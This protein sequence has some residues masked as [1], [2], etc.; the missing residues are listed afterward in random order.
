MRKKRKTLQPEEWRDIDG[1][2]GYQ[3]SNTGYVRSYWE[4]RRKPTGYGTYR[5]LVDNPTIMPMSD[6][7]NGYMKVAIRS[8]DNRAYCRKVHKLVADAFLPKDFLDDSVEYTVDHIRS[9][10]EGKLDNSIGNLQW[11]SRPDNIKKA[12]RDGVCDDRI[13]RS[14]K[15]II[16]IDLWTGEEEYFRSIGDAADAIGIDRTAISHV[17]RGDSTRTSHYTFE[18]AD[19]EDRLLYGQ[20]EHY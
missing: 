3:V 15:P 10:R 19:R 20:E 17:L 1:F 8:S 2:P 13:A 14:R 4:K 18:Y 5:V 12:Y 16:M 9:G 6:D 7:G 11:L